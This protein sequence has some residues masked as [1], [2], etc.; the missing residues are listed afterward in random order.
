MNARRCESTT[1]AKRD[2][3]TQQSVRCWLLGAQHA[4]DLDRKHWA[5]VDGKPYEWEGTR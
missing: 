2:D 3:G 5:V 1:V 4:R